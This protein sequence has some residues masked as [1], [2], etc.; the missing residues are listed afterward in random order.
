[1]LVT[2]AVGE[3]V[4]VELGVLVTWDVTVGVL[5]IVPVAVEEGVLLG[6]ELGVEVVKEVTEGVFVAVPVGEPVKVAE[7]V[8][9][10]VEVAVLV[11]VPVGP[12][13]VGVSVAA[14][15]AGVVGLFLEPQAGMRTGPT[16]I[17]RIPNQGK[18]RTAP[19][20]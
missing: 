5:V 3:L 2:V 20:F 8:L 15:G 10:G 7:T 18:I 19:G 4:G 1:V 16:S 11:G 14:G 17:E 6:V 12:E 9:V 13:G